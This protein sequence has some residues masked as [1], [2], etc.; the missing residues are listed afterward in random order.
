MDSV[1]NLTR[2]AC[3][4]CDS[5]EFTE[6]RAQEGCV[7]KGKVLWHLPLNLGGSWPCGGGGGEGRSFASDL[8]SLAGVEMNHKVGFMIR[9]PERGAV[10]GRN[11]LFLGSMMTFFQ[12]WESNIFLC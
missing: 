12:K 10:K 11:C 2:S 9:S 1:L 4:D 7:G 5:G 3:C 6:A 8:A